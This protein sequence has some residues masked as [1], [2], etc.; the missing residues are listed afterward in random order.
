ME[1]STSIM[2]KSTTRTIGGALGGA[3]IAGGVGAIVGGLSGSSTSTKKIDKVCVDLLLRDISSPSIRIVTFDSTWAGG[4]KPVNIDNKGFQIGI[5]NAKEIA[6]VVS[7][8]IDE[9][10]NG[11]KKEQLNKNK[12]NQ[13]VTSVADE[14][15]KLAKLKEDGILT[16]EEFET[17]KAILLS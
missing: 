3:L 17:Q 14:L 15:Q 16:Q 8:I 1:N 13:K 9:V 7:V 6:N 2:S 12:E 11:W 4:G 10:D 5:E